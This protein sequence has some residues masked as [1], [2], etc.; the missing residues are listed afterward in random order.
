MKTLTY[1]RHGESVSNAGG[2]TMAH[3]AVPLSELGHTQARALA[4]TLGVQPSRVLVSRLVRTH[5]TAQPFLRTIWRA[6]RA[7]CSAG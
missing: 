2:L 5:Q 7:R 6:S 1:I 3:E 4:Q